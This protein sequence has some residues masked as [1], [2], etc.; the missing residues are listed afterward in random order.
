MKMISCGCCLLE[1]DTSGESSVC[2]GMPEIS[3]KDV[4]GSEF[5]VAAP[6]SDEEV[7]KK[8]KKKKK[9]KMRVLKSPLMAVLE[10]WGTQF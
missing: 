10:S 7:L 4:S 8:K 2:P 6:T 3:P 1:Y 9:K 5:E